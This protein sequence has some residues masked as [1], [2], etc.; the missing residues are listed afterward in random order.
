MTVV[1]SVITESSSS[2]YSECF[3]NLLADHNPHPSLSYSEVCNPLK[4][5]YFSI[6]VCNFLVLTVC[7][8]LINLI[9]QTFFLFIPEMPAGFTYYIVQTIPIYFIPLLF[10]KYFIFQSISQVNMIN[11]N[12]LP[13]EDSIQFPLASD[14]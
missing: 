11:M 12:A 6:L 14:L 4:F 2:T 10:K 7:C 3:G 1:T 9:F 5:I 13:L 8:K